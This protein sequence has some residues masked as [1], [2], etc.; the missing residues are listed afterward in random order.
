M[1]KMDFASLLLGIVG[2]LTFGIGMCM[3]LLPEWNMFK[4]GVVVIAIGIVLLLALA[5]LRYNLA[6]RPAVHVNGKLLGKVLFGAV[7]VLVMG[8]GM[9]MAL[10]MNMIIPGIV[11]S[12]VG[13]VLLLCLIPMTMGLK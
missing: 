4:P 11:V 7:G 2:F 9:S 10:V 8:A 3:C 5:V 13:I 12:L 6:G 1:K